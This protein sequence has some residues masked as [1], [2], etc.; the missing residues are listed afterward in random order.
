MAVGTK[1]M[2]RLYLPPALLALSGFLVAELLLYFAT[3]AH[4]RALARTASLLSLAGVLGGTGWALWASWR[5]WHRQRYA[6][7]VSA[8]APGEE[9]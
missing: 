3:G 9:P 6:V 4:A 1:L 5:A 8:A 7:P 2:V